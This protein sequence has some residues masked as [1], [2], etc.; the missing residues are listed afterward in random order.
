MNGADPP[1]RGRLTSRITSLTSGP[2]EASGREEAA[3]AG[4]VD[5][6]ADSN[7]EP[8]CAECGVSGD[9]PLMRCAGFF[10]WFHGSPPCLVACSWYG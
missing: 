10:E 7:E 6:E 8:V 4:S 2:R 1:E 9:E 5:G 3:E